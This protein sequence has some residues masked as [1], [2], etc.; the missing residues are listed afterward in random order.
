MQDKSKPENPPN[1]EELDKLKARIGEL[2]E[3]IAQ[4][5]EELRGKDDR[6]LELER[7]LEEKEEEISKLKQSLAEMND[8]LKRAVT[9]YKAQVLTSN[10]HL[11]EELIK[12]E[13]IEEVNTSLLQAQEVVEKVKKGVQAEI[14]LS[15]F[16][17]GAP[18]RAAPDLSG[19]S[20]R[21]KIKY[22]IGGR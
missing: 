14:S 4:K 5:E 18:E 22:A 7:L 20:P 11:P 6:I 9:S 10:P 1:L 17:L 21:E 12:G 3:L 13:T 8:A 2:E 16:P 15:K 19:L